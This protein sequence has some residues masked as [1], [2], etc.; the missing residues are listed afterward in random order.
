MFVLPLLPL[1]LATTGFAIP[2]KHHDDGKHHEPAKHHGRGS[3]PVP[4]SVL[5]SELP[6]GQTALVAPGTTAIAVS[7]SAG[8][9]NYTCTS[10]GTYS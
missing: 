2:R 5:Q 7:V 10:A 6:S 3:T 1:L 8:N 9:Q 4:G